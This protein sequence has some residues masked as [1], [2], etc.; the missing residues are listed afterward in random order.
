MARFRRVTISLTVLIFCIAILAYRLNAVNGGYTL[1][2]WNN[3]GMHCMD[4]DY[5]IF[6]IL[7]PYNT[8]NAQLIDAR[9]VLIKA[10]Q[11]I[12]V[13]YESITDLSG[14]I[15]TSSA[16]KTN[17]WKY[18]APLFGVVL[19]PDV[20]LAAG[21][22][23]GSGNLPQAMSWDGSRSQFTAEGIPITPYD[24]SGQKN[25][26]PMMHLVARDP[27]NNI[28]ATTDIVLPVSDEMDCSTCHASE[29][30]I[31]AKPSAG[32]AYDSNPERDYRINI[33]LRHDQKTSGLPG[34]QSLLETAG[35]DQGGLYVTAIVK[36]TPILCARC[37]GSNALG[38][39]SLGAT[40]SLTRAVHGGHSQVMDPVSGQ[41]LDSSTNRTACYRCHPGS[42]TK[43]LRGVM[44]NAV[45]SDGSMEIQCQDCHGSMSAV[46]AAGREGWLDEPA[47]QN[48][49]TG[50]ATQNSGQI[51]FT[52]ALDT[53][54]N[55]RM[56][57]SNIFATNSNVPSF[58]LS[59][60][61]FSA[62]HGG[63][64]CE[65][66]H[67]STH[68]EF[69]SSHHNDNVQSLQSQGHIGTITDCPTC[70][71][72]L[73]STF[74][75]GPHG[76]HPIG[77]QWAGN[78]D[79]AVERNG[80]GACRACHGSNDRG[81]VLSRALGDR[82]FSTRF[83]LKQFWR[84][85]QIGCYSCHNGAAS[86]SANPNAPPVV[87]GTSAST[88]SKTPVDVK[89]NASDANQN[90][91]TLR[92]VSQPSHGTVALSGT[93]A[94]YIPNPGYA[95]TDSFTF[96]A[97]DGMAD[98]N[99]GTVALNVAS[100][101]FFPYYRTDANS[102][103]G[104][105]V[106]NYSLKNTNL[107]F[108]AFDPNG[109]LLP[110]P[111]NPAAL[112]L[113]PLSQLAQLGSQIFGGPPA[114]EQ[115]GWVQVGGDIAELGSMFQFGTYTGTQ[116]D[117][118]V[119]V[120]QPSRLFRFTRVFEGARAFRGQSAS[121]FL[122]IINPGSSPITMTINLV[123][124]QPGQA[125]APQKT[126]T[127]Q[128]K[129]ALQGT[130]SQIFGSSLSVSS[131]W[132][133]VQVIAGDGAIGFEMVR[134]PEAQTVI[135][136][137]AVSG[138]APN[139]SYSAQ[140]AIQPDYFTNIKLI[141]TGSVARTATLH[142]IAENGVDLAQPV[143]LDIEVGQSI[144]QDAG[145]MFGL[146]SAVGSLRV[147]ADG[148]GLIGDVIFGDPVAMGYGACIQLQ[149][150]KFTQAVFSQ[151]ANGDNFWTGLALLNPNPQSVSITLDVYTETGILSG[152]NTINLGAG[153]R[154]SRLLAEPGMVPSSGGQM[155]G[156]IKIRSTLPILGQELFG[157][158]GG[159]FLSA[160]PANILN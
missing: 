91:L 23:P 9:G 107:Q 99:L 109:Q 62:G 78:H 127:L 106:S 124:P 73:P 97:W 88:A 32:W 157:D 137:N 49:H 144:E 81:T 145:Q 5:S 70:H 40:P 80:A 76:M 154:L 103:T 37:H 87:A 79:S 90:P 86:E 34:F 116:L 45:A 24:D 94:T 21:N 82:N 89:L 134:F 151:V 60:Y 152:S 140:L 14:S 31:E 118:S 155:R 18:I 149:G 148:P 6:S 46:G 64:Q 69:P 147:D 93:T 50:T 4:S 47:C 136:L 108:T 153:Q 159:R 53:N 141:N 59:L 51:R 95:G 101:I 139:Q 75:G 17:F 143:T 102:Y 57:A 100:E 135:G 122:S 125:L 15:N 12:T 30:S 61:R 105:A 71:T 117:G 58:G 39:V 121:T 112:F 43:C 33:L 44:G 104:F 56:A 83:G 13:T 29:S 133:V 2:A 1:L 130:V 138:T 120:T 128:G 110:L 132:V 114:T 19:Q 123:G 38:T 126:V 150:Q 42:E 25:Y 65:A 119:A 160:V 52:S 48:C 54:G 67:G 3:L 20:G 74:N 63:L 22:M 27:S 55:R 115:A 129:G 84:G 16:G 28:L 68:A 113:A 66:C 77:Q 131:G 92:I 7:P 41:A 72:S 35:Y 11:G 96:A 158:A 85:Y 10:P 142:A 26:Y 8:I 111:R 36:N 98:S 146:S 156:F